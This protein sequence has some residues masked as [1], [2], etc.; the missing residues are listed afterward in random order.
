MTEYNALSI[1]RRDDIRLFDFYAQN[2]VN[3]NTKGS[4]ARQRRSMRMHCETEVRNRARQ[5]VLQAGMITE[6]TYSAFSTL[7]ETA[8]RMP[9]SKLAFFISDG[10]L[11]DTGPRG[12]ITR[13]RLTRITADAR[14]AGVVI[15]SIDARGLVSGNLD[16][17]GS[18]P[19]DPEGRLEASKVRS[20]IESQ[21]GLNALAV[22]TGGRA[23]RNQN[24]FE[25][26]VREAVDETSRF[27]LI[28]WQPEGNTAKLEKLRNIEI[29]VIGRPEFTVR[30]GRNF[31]GNRVLVAQAEP[32]SGDTKLTGPD[33]AL[34]RVLI[35]QVPAAAFPAHLSLVYFDTPVN[36][37]VLTS[38]VEVPS[39]AL[40]FGAD[41]REP[42]K[43]TIAGAVLN[44]HGKSV[45]NFGNVLNV[46]ARSGNKGSPDASK[47]IYN[48]PSPVKPGIYQV[49]A[50]VRDDRSGATGSLHRWIVIPDLARRE[51]SISTVLMGLEMVPDKDQPG[52]RMQW[53]IDRKFLRDSKLTFMAFVYNADAQRGK[54]DVA[55]RAVVLRDGREVVSG[56][57]K[58]IS[59]PALAD[60]ARVP[61][62]GE[63]SLRGLSPGKY[64]LDLTVEDRATQK[65]VS[66][67]ATFVVE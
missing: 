13:D 25:G 44:D 30:S 1:E 38:S 60:P 56:S 48:H 58:K 10:F 18:V 36:G 65:T 11:S 33:A 14:A 67:R 54:P 35:D 28:A 64:I 31:A 46:N 24:Y 23:L 51:L 12:R 6:G 26:F 53:S 55:A 22:D 52:G 42:A 20:I 41:G 8:S 9:G 3:W 39:D 2:C 7:L 4:D 17:A 5:I 16:A 49:R 29:K 32:K 15:Y 37:P 47:V 34:H 19:L 59:D 63:I 50:V 61:V 62:T 45:A 43:L 27:Y 21:E 66:Q 57:F 40:S